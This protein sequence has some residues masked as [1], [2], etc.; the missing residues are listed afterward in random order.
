M[1]PAHADPSCGLAEALGAEHIGAEE[2]GR[3]EHG[4]AVVRLGG[5]VHDD[6]D[7]VLLQ[8][9]GDLV[10]VADVGLDERHPIEAVDVLP[11]P[12]VGQH[13]ESDD[14]IV[15]VLVT[16]VADEVRA[17][18]PGRTGDEDRAHEN[19]RGR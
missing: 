13:V 12:G 7:T 16:P 1:E 6:V 19:Q 10:G 3:L 9:A 5:E 17:D 4:E 15:R 11:H 8:V 2:A 14:V 18:E